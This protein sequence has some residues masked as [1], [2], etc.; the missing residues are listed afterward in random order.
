MSG[1]IWTP[2]T[3]GKHQ[4]ETLDSNS[5]CAYKLLLVSLFHGEYGVEIVM[6]R[7]VRIFARKLSDDKTVSEVVILSSTFLNL[8]SSH[9]DD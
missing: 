7:I 3:F 1:R 6:P 5:A 8:L 4:V 2:E 9:T